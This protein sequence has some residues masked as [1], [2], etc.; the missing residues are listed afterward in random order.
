MEIKEK[1]RKRDK[2]IGLEILSIAKRVGLF[3]DR[4]SKLVKFFWFLIK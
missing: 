1:R 4:E 3:M 2:S